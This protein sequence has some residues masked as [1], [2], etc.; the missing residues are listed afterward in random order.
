MN[1]A[2]R[3]PRAYADPDVL[4][5]AR[6]GP[7]HLTFGFGSHVCP[8]ATLARRVARLGVEVFLDHFPE[9]AVRLQPGFTFAGAITIAARQPDAALALLRFLASP[10][11]ASIVRKAGLSP[12]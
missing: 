7:P 5:L 8:G 11:A 1:A 2:N 10:E 6:D 3:D 12:P 9:G 4:D